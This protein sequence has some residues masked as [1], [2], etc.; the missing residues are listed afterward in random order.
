MNDG[1]EVRRGCRVCGEGDGEGVMQTKRK[2]D[3]RENARPH[4]TA[5]AEAAGHQI[6]VW[7]WRAIVHFSRQRQVDFDINFLLFSGL[8]T[9]LHM[10]SIS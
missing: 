2:R 5:A 1:K 8:H 4:M 9:L 3:G 6:E 10:N 7:R